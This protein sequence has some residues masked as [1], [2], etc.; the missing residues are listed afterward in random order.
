MRDG[1]SISSSPD[2]E[3]IRPVAVRRSP[4]HGPHP[5]EQLLVDER[6]DD[7]VVAPARKAAQAV[8]GLAALAHHDHGDIPVPE[9]ARLALPEPAAELE[10][11]GIREGDV[12]QHEVGIDALEQIERAGALLNRNDV[13]PVL[14]EL[15]LEKR[16][17]RSLVL[18]QEHRR[19]RHGTTLAPTAAKLQMSFLATP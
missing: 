6:P 18:D 17:R 12:E 5:R 8:D 9:A 10:A 15:L 13:E 4:Q 1:R 11:R 2:H 3:L 16:P 7:V 14:G 19:T